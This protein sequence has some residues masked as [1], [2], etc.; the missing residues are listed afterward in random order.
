[1]D[2]P[3]DKAFTAFLGKLMDLPETAKEELDEHETNP[4]AAV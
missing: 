4:G 2:Q 3:H 1:M